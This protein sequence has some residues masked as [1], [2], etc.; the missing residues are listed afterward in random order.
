MPDLR[1]VA[2]PVHCTDLVD[3]NGKV[4]GYVGP[5]ATGARGYIAQSGSE[6]PPRPAAFT[7]HPDTE[8]ARVWVVAEVAR[9]SFRPIQVIR[10]TD[11]PPDA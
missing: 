6:W 10:D 2:G 7:D 8:A 3:E 11:G 4:F 5:L 1:W 9:R